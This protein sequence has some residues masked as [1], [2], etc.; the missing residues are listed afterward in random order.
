MNKTLAAKSAE[1]RLKGVGEDGYGLELDTRK[2]MRK[3]G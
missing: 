3:M 1:K 2:E